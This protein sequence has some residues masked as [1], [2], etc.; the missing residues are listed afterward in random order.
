MRANRTMQKLVVLGVLLGV[1]AGLASCAPPP[2][3]IYVRAGPPAEVVEAIP[4]APGPAY[5]WVRGYYK[6]D[7]DARAYVWMPGHWVV[8][9]QGYREWVPGHWADRD[10]GWVW[11]E[12][13]WH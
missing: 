10:G 8:P 6:W 13:H 9:P 12:G 5:V 2:R 4:A 1:A 11:I 3:R 7:A